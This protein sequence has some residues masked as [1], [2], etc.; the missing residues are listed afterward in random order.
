MTGTGKIISIEK[1]KYT[2]FKINYR[3]N[4]IFVF[5]LKRK[6]KVSKNGMVCLNKLKK[7]KIIKIYP[8]RW[9]Y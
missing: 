7:E 3:S 6:S 8:V 2:Y 9:Y 5:F 4:K 1:K